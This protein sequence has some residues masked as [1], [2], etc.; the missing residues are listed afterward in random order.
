[1]E[2]Q[3]IYLTQEGLVKLQDELKNLKEVKRIEIAEKLKEAISFWD[4]SENAEYE[5]ARNEQA[6]VEKKIIDLEEQ[7]KNVEII[8]EDSHAGDTV[9]MGAEV[10]MRMVDSKEKEVYIIVWTTEADILATPPKISNDSPIGKGLMGKKKWQKVKL[11]V[12]AGNVEYE[13]LTVK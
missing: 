9:W 1:M 5:E 13:I 10:E 3:A 2:A 7:L 11:K 12:P 6:Q 8:T 4:L